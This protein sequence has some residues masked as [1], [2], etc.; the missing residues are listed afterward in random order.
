MGKTLVNLSKRVLKP[1]PIFKSRF[2][3]EI[4]E[5]VHT[6]YRNLRIVNSIHDFVSLAEGFKDALERWK[7][8][9]CPGTGQ[10]HIELCRKKIISESELDSFEVNLNENLYRRNEGSIFSEGN[11]FQDEVYVHM[12][13]RDFR[14]EMSVDEFKEIADA[15]AEA[16]EKLE[17]SDIGSSV[18]AA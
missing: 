3:V 15:I 1:D 14:V 10:K 7:Q 13:I 4:C 2:V 11:S 12:K 9:G 6:H 17:G 5:K 16:K 18:E 8:R